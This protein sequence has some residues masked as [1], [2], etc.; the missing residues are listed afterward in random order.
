ME[1]QL[2]EDLK[3]NSYYWFLLR[4][5]M[6]SGIVEAVNLWIVFNIQPLIENSL[7]TNMSK[8]QEKTLTQPWK[9]SPIYPP[10]HS[11]MG[12]TYDAPV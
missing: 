8:R 4:I 5:R 12:Q 7:S 9:L 2:D 6:Y 1:Y 3:V 11:I 10:R